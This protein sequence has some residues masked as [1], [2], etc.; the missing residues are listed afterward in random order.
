MVSDL[1][2]V[3]CSSLTKSKVSAFFVFC[4][5]WRNIYVIRRA[6]EALFVDNVLFL[7]DKERCYMRRGV[8]SERTWCTISATIC[9]SSSM[10]CLAS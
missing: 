3:N 9:F 2:L 5:S 8:L 7:C 10:N 6:F 4:N 1:F